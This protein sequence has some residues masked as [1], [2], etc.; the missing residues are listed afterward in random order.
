M[1]RS[2]RV[3]LLIVVF[4]ALAGCDL[5]EPRTTSPF[6]G[7]AVTSDQLRA[8]ASRWEADLQAADLRAETEAAQALRRAQAEARNKATHLDVEHELAIAD[9]QASLD[10]RVAVAVDALEVGRAERD[11]AL[12]A[13]QAGVDAAIADL[14]RQG[15]QR[16]AVWGAIKTIPGVQAVPG[17]SAVDAAVGALITGAPLAGALQLVRVRQRRR[18]GG[19]A[20]SLA[21]SEQSRADTERALAT[22]ER[23]AER[24]VDSLDILREKD[25]GVAAAFAAHARLL[26]SWQGP[27]G[28]ALVDRLQRGEVARPA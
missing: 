24:V 20:E 13:M 26:D 9:L 5:L 19:L 14:R 4:A 11:S 18:A 22:T 28:K 3:L 16:R 23:A 17:F 7:E 25:P 21:A 8:E 2:P 6:S 10:E 27:E 12:E 1:Q 15:E